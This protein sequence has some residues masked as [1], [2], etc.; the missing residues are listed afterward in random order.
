[1]NSPHSWEIFA[2]EAYI[3]RCV[4]FG[5]SDNLNLKESTPK[6]FRGSFGNC[7]SVAQAAGYLLLNALMDNALR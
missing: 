4:P 7:K 6:A 3:S 1:M 2:C 5:Y